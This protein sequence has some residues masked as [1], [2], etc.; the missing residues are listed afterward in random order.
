MISN[1][2]EGSLIDHQEK[3]T[4]GIGF[5][6]T[7]KLVDSK[8]LLGDI[9]KDTKLQILKLVQ[10]AHNESLTNLKAWESWLD[11]AHGTSESL[12][13]YDKLLEALDLH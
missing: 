11:S 8:P 7:Y 9:P 6:T 3:Q 4:I 5:P 1:V 2:T 12:W 13:G 10:E